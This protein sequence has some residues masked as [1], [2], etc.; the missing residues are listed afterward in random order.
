MIDDGEGYP[1]QHLDGYKDKIEETAVSKE[2]LD[3]SEFPSEIENI[4]GPD[5]E[6]DEYTWKRLSDVFP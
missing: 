6:N 2:K 1:P 4:L 3:D 5:K